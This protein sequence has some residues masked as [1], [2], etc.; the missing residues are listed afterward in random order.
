MARIREK[1]R[2]PGIAAFYIAFL[3]ILFVDYVSATSVSVIYSGRMFQLA[4]VLLMCKVV[5][6]KYTKTEYIFLGISLATA[7]LSFL[8]VHNY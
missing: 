5:V 6:T 8:H 2:K 4:A 3:L 7:D 1:L